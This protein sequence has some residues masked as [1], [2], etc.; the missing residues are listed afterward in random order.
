MHPIQLVKK[1]L[2]WQRENPDWVVVISG[3]ILILNCII[4]SVFGYVHMRLRWWIILLLLVAAF[5]WIRSMAKLGWFGRRIAARL[6]W[7]EGTLDWKLGLYADAA[8]CFEKAHRFDSHYPIPTKFRVRNLATGQSIV[9][10][11]WPQPSQYDLLLAEAEKYLCELHDQK[12]AISLLQKAI[13]LNPH[14]AE[15]YGMLG[16]IYEGRYDYDE[17]E[18]YYDEGIEKNPTNKELYY[19]R[20][21]FR[22]MHRLD[23]QGAITDLSQAIRLDPNYADAYCFRA[24]AYYQKGDNEKAQADLKMAQDLGPVSINAKELL[25]RLRSKIQAIEKP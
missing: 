19:M 11:T 9:V 12:A 7:K 20:G 15:A 13:Q 3:F 10:Y 8:K 17:A 14:R 21:V 24:A 16:L 18:R 5:S 25:K 23:V 6:W 1:L 2:S 4:G 22:L